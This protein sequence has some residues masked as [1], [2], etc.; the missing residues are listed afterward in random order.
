MAQGRR[1]RTGRRVRWCGERP[2]V[3]ICRPG[4]GFRS[5]ACRRPL[6]CAEE[7]QGHGRQGEEADFQEGVRACRL[8]AQKDRRRG[9]GQG[10]LPVGPLDT[11]SSIRV[12]CATDVA[13]PGRAL[14]LCAPVH[15]RG[16]GSAIGLRPQNYKR[17]FFCACDVVRHASHPTCD[18][19]PAPASGRPGPPRGAGGRGW[20]VS[21]DGGGGS[22]DRDLG[23]PPPACRHRGAGRPER[24]GSTPFTQLAGSHRR[25]RKS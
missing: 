17:M 11:L 12:G 19:H 20:G 18:G 7:H 5:I 25:E 23:H 14:C 3:V 24:G 1:R 2:G 10:L 16:A 21:R 4:L 22:P 13:V 8:R 6:A 9:L 15:T